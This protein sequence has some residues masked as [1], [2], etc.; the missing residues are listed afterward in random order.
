M[1]SR[2]QISTAVDIEVLYKCLALHY[3]QQL[4]LFD[5]HVISSRGVVCGGELC[6][7]FF[8]SHVDLSVS[9]LYGGDYCSMV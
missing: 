5:L 1:M 3:D 4:N 2:V 7:Y 9:V 6:F 8:T